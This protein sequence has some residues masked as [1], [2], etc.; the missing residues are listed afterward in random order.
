[1]SYSNLLTF[2]LISRSSLEKRGEVLLVMMVTC[3]VSLKVMI[4]F[5]PHIRSNS[6]EL[7]SWTINDHQ[8]HTRS[9]AYASFASRTQRMFVSYKMGREVVEMRLL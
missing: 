4:P 3:R 7:G 8:N 5:S 9:M 2:S 6:G 1:M